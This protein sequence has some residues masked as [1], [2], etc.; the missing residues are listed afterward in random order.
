MAGIHREVQG[1]HRLVSRV[2]PNGRSYTV[3][4]NTVRVLAVIDLR[5]SPE[6]I[7]TLLNKKQIEQ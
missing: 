3:H 4:E 1:F 7:A 6:G 2:V 5:R